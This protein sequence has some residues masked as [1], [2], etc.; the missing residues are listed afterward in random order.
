[1][2]RPHL[3]AR[4]RSRFSIHPKVP[5]PDPNALDELGSETGVVFPRPSSRV[6]YESQILDYRRDVTLAPTLALTRR[7]LQVALP[8]LSTTL[9]LM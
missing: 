4:H 2:T 1:M 3:R 8:R 7:L 5:N 9:L 6:I